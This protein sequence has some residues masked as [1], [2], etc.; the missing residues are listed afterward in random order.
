MAISV[1]VEF[2]RSTFDA[3]SMFDNSL[4]ESLPHPARLHNAFVD[5]AALG[6]VDGGFEALMAWERYEPPT[7]FRPRHDHS[8]Q[9]TGFVPTNQQAS[10]ADEMWK[11]SYPGRVAK[12]PR[13]W[14]RIA[15]SNTLVYVWDDAQLNDEHAHALELLAKQ[16]PYLGRA[17]SPVLVRVTRG[18]ANCEDTHRTLLPTEAYEGI[19]MSA[20]RPGYTAALQ[21][22]FDQGRPAHEV[23]RRWLSYEEPKPTDTVARSPFHDPLVLALAT[24]QDARAVR[25]LTGALR[26]SLESVLDPGP[27]ELHGHADPGAPT[28]RHQIAIVP[29]TSSVGPYADGLVRALALMMPLSLDDTTCR[30]LSRALARINELRLGAL[31]VVR[32]D[33]SPKDLVALRVSTWARPSKVWT[34]VTPMVSDRYLKANDEAGWTAQILSA[35]RHGD[36]PVPVEI[37][38]SEVP[39]VHGSHRASEYDTRR[40]LPRDVDRRNERKRQRPRPARH[41]RVE[42]GEEVSGPIALGNMR[43][44]GLGLCIPVTVQS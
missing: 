17:T 44:L 6:D 10:K 3:S 34:T 7:I 24:P 14:P 26:A 30:E 40:P 32:F 25:R 16:I 5:A 31:G 2:V 27:V 37:E 22:A 21:S 42:F 33:R 9:R 39:W 11:T 15:L 12:G 38:F 35:C 20:A 18:L 36:L 28:P 29:L 23:P 1:E 8:S 43:Y 4:P 41:V 19:E 13:T